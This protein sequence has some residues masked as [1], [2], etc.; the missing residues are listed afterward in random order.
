MSKRATKW[1]RCINDI[2]QENK[3]LAAA[4]NAGIASLHG[5]YIFPL[6][7]D[8]RLR[9]VWIDRGIEILNTNLRTGV[10]CGDAEFFGTKT[11]RC[12]GGP[13]D[14]GKP[15]NRCSPE[16][17]RLRRKLRLLLPENMVC[18]IGRRG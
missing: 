12:P 14:L 8:D 3:G 17:L 16:Q 6:D 13:F 5:E 1:M 7:A 9:S 4:R 15:T 10:V 18:C 2:W 11:G